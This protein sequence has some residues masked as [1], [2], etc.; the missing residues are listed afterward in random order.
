M[1]DEIDYFKTLHK[2]IELIWTSEGFDV[3]MDKDDFV[4]LTDLDTLRNDCLLTIITRFRELKDNPT[5]K[6]FGCKAY[7]LIKSN[8]STMVIYKLESYFKEALKS[9]RRVYMVDYVTVTE[10]EDEPYKY[11]VAFQVRSRTDEIVYGETSIKN[12]SSTNLI[13]TQIYCS[14]NQDYA[15]PYEPCLITFKCTYGGNHVLSNEIVSIY[16]NNHL[17]TRRVTDLDGLCSFYYYPSMS[18]MDL[19]IYASF[20]GASDKNKCKS[21]ILSI[22]STNFYFKQLNGHLLM[23]Y[24]DNTTPPTVTLNKTVVDGEIHFV[25]SCDDP[26]TF[27]INDNG[28]LIGEGI[29]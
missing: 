29:D 10:N 18:S 4:R 5:Y 24:T 8:K 27:H 16:V 15:N 6:E 26:L 25:M 28:H 3:N 13:P 7:E 14:S 23:I 21:N 9:M 2:D 12:I 20:E 17:Y 11:N 1:N 22:T 19:E